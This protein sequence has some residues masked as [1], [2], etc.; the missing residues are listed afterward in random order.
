MRREEPEK[1]QKKTNSAMKKDSKEK[2]GRHKKLFRCDKKRNRR[3]NGKRMKNKER[4]RKR[5][6]GKL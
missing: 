5:Q 3:P 1:G 4:K 6:F 2:T